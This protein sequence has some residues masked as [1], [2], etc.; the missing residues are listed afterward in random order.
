MCF[1]GAGSSPEPADEHNGKPDH[2]R[3]EQ[4]EPEQAC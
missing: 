2:E 3:D 4:G 1:T